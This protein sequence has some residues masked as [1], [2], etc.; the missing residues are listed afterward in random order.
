MVNDVSASVSN[1]STR[2]VKRFVTIVVTEPDN[3]S[4][5][6]TEKSLT[7]ETNEATKYRF[8]KAQAEDDV[9]E[10][11]S[12]DMVFTANALH[13]TDVDRSLSASGRALPSRW[14]IAQR[15]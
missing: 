11:G 5:A 14:S 15:A 3:S 4:R 12:V 8:V 6:I 10:P 2:L 9:Q 13:W 1:H 7:R